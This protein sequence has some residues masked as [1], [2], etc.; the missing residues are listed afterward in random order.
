MSLP[1]PNLSQGVPERGCASR[2]NVELTQPATKTRGRPRVGPPL[3]HS[4]ITAAAHFCATVAGMASDTRCVSPG[5][6]DTVC[7]QLTGLLSFITST[8]SVQV[9]F[10]PLLSTGVT[11]VRS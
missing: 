6:S 3:F 8:S 7:D 10:P 2:L 11:N 9:Y 4:P 5:I 1:E